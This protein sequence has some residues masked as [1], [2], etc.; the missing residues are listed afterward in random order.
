M[1]PTPAF[2]S[3]FE[4]PFDAAVCGAGLVGYAAA[5]RLAAEGR[6]VLLLEPSGQLLWEAAR[7]LENRADG[8]D[9]PAWLDWLASLEPEAA[10]QEWFDPAA[11]EIATAHALAGRTPRLSTLLYAMP[12][13]VEAAGGTIRSVS[14]ATKSGPRTVRAR[15]WV[16]A[17]ENG[18]LARLAD[19][20]LAPRA[21][22]ALYRSAALQAPDPG[23]LDAAAGAF[24]REHPEYEWLRSHRAT[25]RRVRWITGGAWHREVTTLVRGLRA[26]VP[27]GFSVSHIGLGD[28]PVY[29]AAP[30]RATAL[31]N[32]AIL[33]PA[34]RAEALA[35][36]AERFLLGH[37]VSLE[38]G[39][40]IAGT[41]P[42]PAETVSCE[43]AVA[44]A[45]TSG[46]LAAI[47]AGRSG[48]RTL[49]FDPAACLGGTGTGGGINAYFFGSPDGMHREVDERALALSELFSG[50]EQSPRHSWH[51]DAKTIV[52]M[53]CFEEAGVAFFGQTQLWGVD[54]N[55][56]GRVTA[57]QVS[58]GGR[59][60]RI[61]ARAFIDATGDGDLCVLA[62]AESAAGRPGDG[63]ALAYSQSARFLAPEHLSVRQTNFDAG[64]ADPADPEDLSRA[65]LEGV[66]QYF[67][68][69]RR[70]GRRPVAVAPLIGIRQSRQIRADLEISFA[71]TVLHARF[72]DAVGRTD[73]I[74]DTHSADLEFESDEMAFYYWTCRSRHHR[75]A[76]ELPY[77]ML[78]PRGLENVWVPC[79]AAG[80]TPDASYGLRM[81]R[82][83]QRLGE[84][85][86]RAAAM[87]AKAGTGS[88]GIDLR[89]L[90]AALGRD[91]LAVPDLPGEDW[92]AALDTGAPGVHLW[93]ISRQPGRFRQALIDRLK[94][95]GDVSFYA[96]AILA[97]WGE[98]CAE[99]R[100]IESMERREQGPEPGDRGSHGQVADVPFWYQ[101]LTLLRVN[102]TGAALPPLHRL[103]R[104]P[105]LPFNVRTA[106]ALTLE[107]LASR[108]GRAPL[109]TETL[110]L[111]TAG[112]IRDSVLP[113]SRSLWLELAGK[114]Q[115][116]LGNFCGADTSSDHAWQLH[117][118]VART[119]KILGLPFTSGPFLHDPRGHVRAVFQRLA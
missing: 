93:M 31:G 112:E 1:N 18:I 39:G 75:L 100:L 117:L 83:L 25:E 8:S 52:L 77:R 38:R 118:V 29:E 33:G 22:R 27:N 60:A 71:D 47:A 115:K 114:P 67:D 74:A 56:H 70:E 88:R 41:A 50:R 68:P 46:A 51:P 5:R 107:R 109:L 43:V 55:G 80:M 85:A 45:G 9:D 79:R 86:G 59:P 3:V 97:M 103:A 101:A 108:L 78:L 61:A 81:Q 76:C 19:P 116:R 21:P 63:G 91:G 58:V 24:L 13:S 92:L 110:E 99:P 90:Q 111:L 6:E 119:R 7:A 10:P 48:A 2:V 34:L 30:A 37:G 15:H 64:W 82:D 69:L 20:R 84:A 94:L 54:R 89:A 102:G 16:D 73:T 36:P 4:R 23:A 17:T 32:L 44:G 96:A 95:P 53:E 104:E 40:P 12:L 28:Y 66:A 65:R 26:A 113:P 62:G 105:R 98:P 57:L 87:A 49:V 42:A 11:A 106:L 72:D 35:T 14:I